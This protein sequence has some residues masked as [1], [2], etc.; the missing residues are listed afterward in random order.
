MLPTANFGFQ[1]A[2]SIAFN[3]Q[4]PIRIPQSSLMCSE[5]F[6]IPVEYN[7]LP[8]FG[9]GLLLGVWL[10]AGTIT[11]A[12]V[13]RNSA[14]PNEFWSYF[15]GILL[16]AAAIVVV[17][18]LFPEGLPIRGY[19][20]FVLAG[21]IVG[22]WMAIHRARQVGL[23][24][25]ILMSLAFSLFIC[26][27]IG[28]RLF[29]VIEYWDTRFDKGD[30]WTSLVEIVKYTEGGLV[31]YGS[32]IG[33]AI[34]Y[35]V[36]ARRHKLPVLALADLIVPSVMAGLAFGRIGCLMN[37]CCYG[38]ETDHPWGVTFPRDSVPYMEQFSNGRFLGMQLGPK[39]ERDQ[40]PVVL[41]VDKQSPAEQAGIPIDAR[42]TEINGRTTDDLAS[43]QQHLVYATASGE[44]LKMKT[45]DGEMYEV[46]PEIP[47]RSL[48]VH[49]TQIY[50]AINAGL[51]AWL[52]WSFYPFRQRDGQ[53]AALLLVLYPISR[54]LLE[55]IRID[56][57]AI[58]GTGLSIS[59]N[60]SVLLLVAAVAFWFWLWKQP[61]DKPLYSFAEGSGFRV[62]S[63]G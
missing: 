16:G 6:R 11:V 10:V 54:F 1:I 48:P 57:S 45:A 15:P 25:D 40:R 31:F 59:Q 4:S 18:K 62:Q 42:V 9:W 28:A 58:F 26:G 21:S 55:A 39:S 44:P 24:P 2:E 8:I 50:S 30:W 5:L 53:V 29:F 22:I 46:I 27:I 17:P 56:E 47:P 36:F 35:L 51:L 38:G 12:Y 7:G 23:D 49:P 43:V 37:G 34:A 61:A 41:A 63:S 19:G 14:R 60:I 33:G 3:P 52:L 32:I 13:V 20:V